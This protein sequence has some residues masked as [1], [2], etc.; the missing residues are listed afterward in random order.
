MKKILLLA[1]AGHS[2]G[3]AQVL[4]NAADERLKTYVILDSSVSDTVVERA[5]H[6]FR[7]SHLYLGVAQ[8]A[9]EVIYY[10]LFFVYVRQSW[11]RHLLQKR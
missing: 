5:E 4:A 6:Q 10:V 3:G 1:A 7:T 2:C 8:A 11:P 9:N